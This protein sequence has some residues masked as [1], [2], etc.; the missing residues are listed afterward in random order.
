MNLKMIGSAIKIISILSL[1]IAVILVS[2]CTGAQILGSTPTPVPTPVPTQEPTSVP[3]PVAFF[4]LNPSSGYAPLQVTFTDESSNKPSAW[5][6]SFGDGGSSTLQNPSHIYN[7]AG[8]YTVSLTV[9]N[10]AG[11]NSDSKTLII[12]PVPTA[13]IIYVT[14]VPTPVPTIAP[15]VAPTRSPTLVPT[16]S[17]D[18]EITAINYKIDYT[19]TSGYF[20][21]AKQTGTG[22]T[23]TAG[24]TFT[25]SVTFTSSAAIFSHTIDSITINT[26]GFTL[27]SVSPALP[28]GK[29]A[30]EDSITETL[31]IRAPSEAYTGTLD[32][33]ISTS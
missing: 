3:A 31:T 23:I 15:T 17:P 22:A 25:K 21:P 5:L 11:A 10:A 24:S 27:I 4:N 26:P 8:T 20:G 18:V 12:N 9:V 29:I 19:G 13:Q 2:G 14:P 6:W 28:T 7:N 1:I 16:A 32:L 30:P 33:V